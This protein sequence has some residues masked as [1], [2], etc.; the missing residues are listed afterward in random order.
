MRQ[1]ADL[2]KVGVELHDLV[3]DSTSLGK[4]RD[5]LSNTAESKV[6]S[7]GHSSGKLGFW[8]FSNNRQCS[9]SLGLGLFNVSSDGRVDTTAKT[10]VR[11]DG[12]V[13]DLGVLGLTLGLGG[14]SLLEEYCLSVRVRGVLC[15]LDLPLLAAPYFLA[16][17]IARSALV[18]FVDATTFMDCGSV[19]AINDSA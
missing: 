4:S 2:V 7:L 16:S 11:G 14:L 15:I 8:L 13:E 19:S 5:I 10:S 9:W 1:V 3:G 18:N 17:R 6:Q 12:E